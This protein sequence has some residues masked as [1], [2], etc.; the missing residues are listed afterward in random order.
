MASSATGGDAR[1]GEAVRKAR[2]YAA[3]GDL[4]AALRVAV[5]GDAFETAAEILLRQARPGAAARMALLGLGPDVGRLAQAGAE[6][7]ELAF[8]AV[9]WLRSAG[10]TRLAVD[11]L[12]ALRV[13]KAAQSLAEEAG[14]LL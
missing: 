7:R 14:R 3:R 10:E 4:Q 6:S 1:R 12:L 5:G 11:L 8:R 2:E 13:V 9:E